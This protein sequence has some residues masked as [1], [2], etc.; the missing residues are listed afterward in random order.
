[1]KTFFG[2][3]FM[4]KEELRKEG[5][6]YPIKLEYYKIKDLKSKT[7]IF[8][9]EVVKTEYLNENIRVEKAAIDKLTNDEKIENSILDILKRNEVTPVI[10]EDVIEDLVKC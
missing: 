5:I 6:L 3:M 8:G 1:M 4:N 10:L 9:G 2:G 7:D